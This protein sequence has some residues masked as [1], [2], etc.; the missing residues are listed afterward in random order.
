MKLPLGL[1][2]DLAQRLHTHAGQPDQQDVGWIRLDPKR[3][4]PAAVLVPLVWEEQ[5]WRLLFTRRAADLEDHG[6]QVS[7]P[8]GAWEE[9][10]GDLERT[11]LRE[12]WEEVG[13][14]PN[15]VSVIGKMARLDLI[16]WFRVTPVVGV[17]G[18]PLNLKINDMEVARAF[19]VPLD[20]LADPDNF[21]LRPRQIEG[22]SI[23]VPYYREY[24]GEVIWGAT[25]KITQEFLR[26]LHA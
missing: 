26:L 15:S 2:S 11:A 5:G 19:T 7:F 9:Q 25:A 16:S 20:W 24:D 1:P 14:E 23:Q 4:H 6:G 8:G 21:E 10:D 17:I 13:I 12:A 18:T 22:A 3:L